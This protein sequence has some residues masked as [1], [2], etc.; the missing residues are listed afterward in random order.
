MYKGVSS[1]LSEDVGTADESKACLRVEG[2]DN[3][4][5]SLLTYVR[6]VHVRTHVRTY[7]YIRIR[8]TY[9]YLR[10]Y[11]QTAACLASHPRMSTWQ[12]T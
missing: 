1:M 12:N 10:T 7:R 11:V 2:L 5:K 6:T 4:N 3:T 8:Y 9:T